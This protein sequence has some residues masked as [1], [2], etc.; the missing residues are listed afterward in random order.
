MYSLIL[1]FAVNF[2]TFMPPQPSKTFDFTKAT[3]KILHPLQKKA[4]D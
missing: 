3:Q 2:N 1:G 4:L